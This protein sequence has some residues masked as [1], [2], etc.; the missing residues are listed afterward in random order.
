VIVKPVSEW[1]RQAKDAMAAMEKSGAKTLDEFYEKDMENFSR[2][3]EAMY[4]L[5]STIEP[6]L[7]RK[8]DLRPVGEV[9]GLPGSDDLTDAEYA[10]EYGERPGT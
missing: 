3:I 5:G 10:G 1:I 7:L 2:L 9:L 6:E 4:A 8:A